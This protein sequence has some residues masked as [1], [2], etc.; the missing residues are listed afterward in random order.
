MLLGIGRRL[1]VAGADYGLFASVRW[2]VGLVETGT[3][4]SQIRVEE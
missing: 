4:A 1:V 3:G 2:V